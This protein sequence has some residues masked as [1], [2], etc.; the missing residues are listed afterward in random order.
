MK[1]FI[2]IPITQTSDMSGYSAI[3]IEFSEENIAEFRRLQGVLTQAKEIDSKLNEI[4]YNSVPFN[5]ELFN[6]DFDSFGDL[7][8][9][10]SDSKL[11]DYRESRNSAVESPSLLVRE[12]GLRLSY[13]SKYADGE[14]YG[15]LDFNEIEQLISKNFKEYLFGK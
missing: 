7:V 4:G 1:P 10:V 5:V 9:E 14:V 13:A 6:D 2:I 3:A 11:E 15:S 8:V 12:Y